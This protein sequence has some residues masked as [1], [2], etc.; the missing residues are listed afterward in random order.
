MASGE[1]GPRTWYGPT[2]EA[3]RLLRQTVLF[4]TLTAFL[5]TVTV[6][7]LDDGPSVGRLLAVS[8]SSDI[9]D[10]HLVYLAVRLRDDVLTGDPDDCW[11]SANFPR[12]DQRNSS[13][14][15]CW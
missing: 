10:G 1:L 6:L 11:R 7:S 2:A 15:V 3:R 14:W 13:P 5:K 8:D 12:V 9:V 4:L